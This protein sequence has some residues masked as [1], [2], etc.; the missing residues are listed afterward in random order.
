MTSL[1]PRKTRRPRRGSCCAKGPPGRCR[2]NG[3]QRIAA[4]YPAPD[5][6]VFRSKSKSK[7]KSGSNPCGLG[8]ETSVKFCEGMA[9]VVLLCCGHRGFIGEGRS[10]DIDSIAIWMGWGAVL[11]LS[12][13]GWLVLGE[14]LEIGLEDGFG[15]GGGGASS[16]KGVVGIGSFNHHRD[17]EAW[18]FVWGKPCEP[19]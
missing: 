11:L 14:A 8:M 10:R 19:G 13:G 4:P 3:R 12:E 16:V 7:S 5:Q 2:H 9:R 1:L 15:D 6:A 17:C 18:F